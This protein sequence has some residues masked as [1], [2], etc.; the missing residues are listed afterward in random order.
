MLYLAPLLPPGYGGPALL[1]WRAIAY[2]GVLVLGAF[3]AGKAVRSLLAGETPPSELNG[4]AEDVPLVSPLTEPAAGVGSGE[5][6]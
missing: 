6:P 3:V 2:Y 4:E 5:P 1:A